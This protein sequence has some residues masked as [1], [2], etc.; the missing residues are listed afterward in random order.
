MSGRAPRI[1]L[2][3]VGKYGCEFARLARL[4]GWP[5]VAAVN[6]AGDKI[7]RSLAEL[8]GIE[9]RGGV[10]VQDCD[11]LDWSTMDADIGVVFT[12]D[13]L[14]N[15]WPAYER[16]LT[17]GMD[18]V[19]HGVQSYY[20]WRYDP[21]TS[22]RIDGLAKAQGQTFTG[23][24]IWDMSRI[25]AGILLAGPCVS[26]IAMR[27]ES[28]TQINYPS[29]RLVPTYGLDLTPE[30]YLQ[31]FGSGGENADEYRHAGKYQSIAE[32]VLSALGYHVL[33]GTERREALTAAE[34]VFC[35]ALGRDIEPGRV[36]GWAYRSR[37][38]TR[39]GVRADASM[40]MRL[41]RDDQPETMVWEIDGVPGNRLA[42]ERRDSIT[43]SASSVLNR[44]PDV[45][46]ARPGIQLLSRLGP[47]RPALGAGATA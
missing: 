40:E 42:I 41:L 39:E 8:A 12:T 43:A 7:G 46:A 38:E 3:G 17:A 24:G 34:P 26:I 19:C 28:V 30:E 37:I 27:H 16:L 21:D 33:G 45:I 15:N 23:T 32:Q 20:P 47:M 4:R 9:D 10:V 18:V 31:R 36:V 11:T 5:I 25:W 1:L 13:I 22:A 35:K 14:R 44:I 2:Y 6:R 29:P